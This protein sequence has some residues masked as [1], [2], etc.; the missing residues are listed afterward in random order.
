MNLRPPIAAS[1]AAVIALSVATVSCAEGEPPRGL[2]GPA[3]RVAIEVAPLSLPGIGDVEIALSVVG[4]AGPVWSEPSLWT[5]HFGAAG[6]GLAYIGPCDA[7]GD[8]HHRIQ[9]VVKTLVD[10]GGATVA[11]DTWVNPAPDVPLDDPRALVATATC[12]ENADVAV[13]FDLVIARDARQGFFDIAVDF[14]D[15]F[16]SAKLD[17][18]D[19]AGPLALLH[20]PSGAREPTAVMAFA[21]AAGDE[22]PVTLY[23]SN[24]T[25]RCADDEGAS[26]YARSFAAAADHEGNQG[27]DG[28]VPPVIFEVAHYWGKEGFAFDK[29]YWNHALGLNLGALAG[30]GRCELEAWGTASHE[31][32]SDLTP[33]AG[34]VHP[35][36]HWRATLT[37]DGALVCDRHALGSA[38]VAVEYTHGEA[39]QG[40]AASY[41]C[42]EAPIPGDQSLACLGDDATAEL[43]TDGLL[44]VT[45]MA[46]DTPVTTSLQLEE[47]SRLVDDCCLHACC[48]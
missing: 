42:G 32:W 10:D 29:C 3:G 13:V 25:V 26:T 22:Q 31:T 37:D 48:R 8:G 6:L 2:D 21:C 46:G 5:S 9:L 14:E 11:P 12:R 39:R 44:T 27:G 7:S 34:R 38:E 17:C 19:D 36:L 43:T 15:V 1:L 4:P 30:L 47:G 16:C 33:P 41:R 24:V 20:G 18:Q 35:V 40:F 45:V 23:L 28:L